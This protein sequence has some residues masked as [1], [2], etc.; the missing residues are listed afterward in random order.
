M[1]PIISKVELVATIDAD[2]VVRGLKNNDDAV[3]TFIIQMLDCAG[4]SELEAELIGRIQERLGV[5]RLEVQ[6]PKFTTWQDG[7]QPQDPF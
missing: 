3:L 5:V 2:D 7:Q 6:Q 4:S 1:E